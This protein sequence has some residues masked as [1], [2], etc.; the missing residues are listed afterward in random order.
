MNPDDEQL[1][2]TWVTERFALGGAIWNRFN[3][4]QL[5]KAGITHVVDLETTF[6]DAWLGGGTGISAL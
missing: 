2:Y 4:R 6:D 3:M 1:D 5:A